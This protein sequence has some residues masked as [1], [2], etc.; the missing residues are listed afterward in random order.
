MHKN[1]FHEIEEMNPE[2]SKEILMHIA[3]ENHDMMENVI[4]EYKYK[5]QFGCH[6]ATEEMY[7]KF[8][9]KLKWANKIGYGPKW[10]VE[11]IVSLSGINFS[12]VPYTK[13]DYAFMVNFFYAAFCN[14]LINTNDFLNMAKSY[15]ENPYHEK[16]AER[17]YRKAKKHYKK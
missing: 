7:N 15:L 14:A 3:D 11:E 8:V 2:E 10:K 4:D 6:I 9:N 12:T 1:I 16:P 13:Y 17:A 5:K